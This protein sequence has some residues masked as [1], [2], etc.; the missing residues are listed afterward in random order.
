MNRATHPTDVP[1]HGLISLS[2]P[3]RALATNSGSAIIPRT[4]DT[5]SA[6]PLLMRCSAWSRVVMRPV[7]MVG[8]S[9]A[10]VTTSLVGTS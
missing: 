7:T 10:L 6:T 5:K 4:I 3:S 1:M 2:R 9:T 8:T